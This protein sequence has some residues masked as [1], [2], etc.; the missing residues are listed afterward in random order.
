MRP[1]IF[2]FWANNQGSRNELHSRDHGVIQNT[3][4][5]FMQ[6]LCYFEKSCM[7]IP[8][9]SRRVDSEAPFG[10]KK[11]IQIK[12]ELKRGLYLFPNVKKEI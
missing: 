8:D 4:R 12:E 3:M 1:D 5:M 2:T 9:G 10:S 7:F 6:V 11:K